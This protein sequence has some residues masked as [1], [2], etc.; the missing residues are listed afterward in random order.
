MLH[1][2]C[3]VLLFSDER[4]LYSL[5]ARNYFREWLLCLNK[6]HNFIDFVVS[7]IHRGLFSPNFLLLFCTEAIFFL[8]SSFCI[9]TK[10]VNFFLS[11]FC[12]TQRSLISLISG[13]CFCT[14]PLHCENYEKC[15]AQKS[16]NVKKMTIVCT[17]RSFRRKKMTSV[18][19]RSHSFFFRSI[20]FQPRQL[21]MVVYY[22]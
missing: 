22:G 14:N 3:N 5:L 21:K 10:A 19:H 4:H 7:S 18:S 16:F 15:A 9:P 11:G 8:R 2:L 17:Q 12:F 13:F 6:W 1:N 20:Y